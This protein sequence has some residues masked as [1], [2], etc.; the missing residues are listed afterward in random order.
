MSEFA[1]D[2]FQER[3]LQHPAVCDTWTNCT[4]WTEP[5]FCCAT[6]NEF[7]GG[8]RKLSLEIR[9]V[10]SQ[11]LISVIFNVVSGRTLVIR[12]VNLL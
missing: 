8:R 4:L 6:Q 1:C 3:A 10:A 9:E 11:P 2:T 7:G 5:G 12:P